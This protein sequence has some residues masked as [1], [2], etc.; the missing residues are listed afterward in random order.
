MTHTNSTN[1]FKV[2]HICDLSLVLLLYLRKI[3]DQLEVYGV[4]IPP[5]N[6]PKCQSLSYHFL[7]RSTVATVNTISSCWFG[8]QKG[9]TW[10]GQFTR[11]GFEFNLWWEQVFFLFWVMQ[12]ALFFFTFFFF[13]LFS[14]SFYS[15]SPPSRLYLFSSL[16][17]ISV[18]KSC[19]KEI[20]KIKIMLIYIYSVLFNVSP[21][22]F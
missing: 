12:I 10:S 20:T 1:L 21:P 3:T 16:M 19:E 22:P 11:F 17:L 14:F 4:S 2:G 18:A 6:S 13:V 7:Y 9:S 8:K 15:P 5:L